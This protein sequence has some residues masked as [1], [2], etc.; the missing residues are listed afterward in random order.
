MRQPWGIQR[1]RS[2]GP[3]ARKRGAARPNRKKEPGVAWAGLVPRDDGYQVLVQTRG[4]HWSSFLKSKRPRFRRGLPKAAFGGLRTEEMLVSSF[5][6]DTTFSGEYTPGPTFSGVSESLT[7][8]SF[9]SL[10]MANEKPS[11]PKSWR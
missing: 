7:G 2:R 5:S 11:L 8:L 6:R 1:R 9:M 3:R 4:P 10:P